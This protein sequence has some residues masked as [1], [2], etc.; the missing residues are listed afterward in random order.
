MADSAQP[1][2]M[3]AMTHESVRHDPLYHAAKSV[4]ESDLPDESKVKLVK[5]ISDARR[6]HPAKP[7]KNEYDQGRV[8]GVPGKFAAVVDRVMKAKKGG[9]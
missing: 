8:V 5:H 6:A 1:S 7:A 4:H 2:I 9:K 3:D